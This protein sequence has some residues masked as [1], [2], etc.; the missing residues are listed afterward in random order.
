MLEDNREKIWNNNQ[1]LWNCLQNKQVFVTGGT[2]FFGKSLLD[3]IIDFNTH[4]KLN[5]NLII[6]TRDP[7]KFTLKFPKLALNKWIKF[8]KGNI[9]DFRQTKLQIDY[10]LHFANPSDGNYIKESP[11]EIFDTINIGSRNIFEFAKLC[12]VTA[13]LQT[14]SGAVY[15]KQ[16]SEIE[17]IQENFTGAPKMTDLNAGYAEGKRVAELIGNIYSKQFNFEHK[18]ARCFAFLGPYQELNGSFAIGNF[19]RDA[20]F[21]N[22]IIVNGDGSDF[23]SYMYSDDLIL[24]LLTILVFGKTRT[25]YNVGSDQSISIKDL[26]YLVSK[27]LNNDS[28]IEIK[29]LATSNLSAN[30]YVPS[31]NFFNSEFELKDQLDLKSAIKR[32]ADEILAKKIS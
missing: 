16:P 21:G 8:Q 30:R 20:L 32:T 2:G 23:R 13:I 22:K 31:M 1:K 27:T 10:I 24:A 17:N 29:Q 3:L 19:I 4:K 11:M 12:E 14:S 15:G 26:A 5:L 6:L 9:L 7:E 18:I 28:K 25:P